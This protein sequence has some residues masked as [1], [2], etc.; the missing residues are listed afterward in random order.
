MELSLFTKGKE[1]LLAGEIDLLNGNIIVLLV[2]SSYL[3]DFSLDEA[4]TDIPDS[5]IVARETL[6]S[7]SVSDGVFDA[8][9]IIFSDVAGSPVHHIIIYYEGE[10]YAQSWLVAGFSSS[11]AIVT[12]DGSAI[13]VQWDA[14]VNKIFAL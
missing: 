3:I 6:N 2:D 13:T 10:T 11:S 5:S 14:G 8:D 12:P 4:L 1:H 9:D 7:T